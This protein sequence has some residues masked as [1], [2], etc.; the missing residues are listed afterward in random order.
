MHQLSEPHGARSRE[1]S[2]TFPSPEYGGL[3]HKVTERAEQV[4]Q[5]QCLTVLGATM[6]TQVTK[7]VMVRALWATRP[8]HHAGGLPQQRGGS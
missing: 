2:G 8:P 5:K 7:S 4:I 3:V 1:A 6:V